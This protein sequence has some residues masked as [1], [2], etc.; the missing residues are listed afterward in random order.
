MSHSRELKT[1]KVLDLF[2]GIGGFSLGLE[3]AGM[4]TIAFCEFDECARKV[5]KKHWPNVPIYEDVRTL[6][7]TKF[8][9]SVDVVCG[10][11]PCQDLS[12]AGKQAGF[13]GDRSN[14]YREMLRIISECMPRYAIF[15][16]V[17]GL[18]SGNGGRW[19]AKFLYDLAEIGY[20]AE[21]HCI[22][23]SEFGANHHRD[24]VWIIAYPKCARR[25]GLIKDDWLLSSKETPF[26]FTM[27]RAINDWSELV[28]S[29]AKV[30][31][32][33]GIPVKLERS[34]IKQMGNAVVP[35]IPEAIGRAIMK[36]EGKEI[37]S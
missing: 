6:D 31:S 13:E 18:L 20:D 4:E 23:A 29:F 36:A 5:L 10:G 21:W 11:F 27:Y 2:S 22:S 14:L 37:G 26:P 25:E 12:S 32:N 19:F 28:G 3:R 17:T 24:R 16:N 30:R 33:N 35:Q 8:R 15:E 1:M 34:R 9:G 7:A